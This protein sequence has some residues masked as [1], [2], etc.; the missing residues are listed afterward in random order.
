MAEVL[1]LQN[2]T[3]T[4]VQGKEKINI[5]NGISLSIS[6]GETLAIVGESGSGKS[7]LL[8]IA[9]MMDRQTSGEVIFLGKNSS[10]IKEKEVLSLRKN[11]IG[12]VYQQNYLLSD[13]SALENILMPLKIRGEVK[14][15]TR[16]LDLLEKIGLSHRAKNRPSELSGGERQRV[17]IARAIA[18]KPAIVF[19]DEPT[20]NLDAKNSDKVSNILFDFVASEGSSLMLITHNMELAKRCDRVLNLKNGKL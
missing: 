10:S 11:K 20:G 8:H 13:F 6:K 14:D 2:I 9:G 3:K 17:A 18:N 19:A 12:F 4:F 5:L 16:A 7:T 15:K 1:N